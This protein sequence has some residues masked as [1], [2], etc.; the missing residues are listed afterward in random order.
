MIGR[1]DHNGVLQLLGLQYATLKN[2]L[3]ES[4]LKKRYHSPIDATK[5]G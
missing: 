1:D 5:Y 4:E 2:R 3:A